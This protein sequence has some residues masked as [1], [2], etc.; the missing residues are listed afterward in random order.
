MP[1]AL[2][3]LR[4]GVVTTGYPRQPDPYAETFPATVHPIEDAARFL[5]GTSM[6][7]PTIVNVGHRRDL[8][9]RIEVPATELARMAEPAIRDGLARRLRELGFNFVTLD[10]E[11]FRSGSLNTLVPLEQKLLFKKP[12]STG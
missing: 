6:P 5:V 8:D 10:L 9:L 1:W 7:L 11:G 3:G 2:R 4:N 12:P